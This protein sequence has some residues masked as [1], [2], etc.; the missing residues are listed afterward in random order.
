MMARLACPSARTCPGS[1]T[2]PRPEAE[3]LICARRDARPGSQRA[4]I[5][6]DLAHPRLRSRAQPHTSHGIA[7]HGWKCWPLHKNAMPE[8][9][10]IGRIGLSCAA[11][12][13]HKT[14][15]LAAGMLRHRG[16]ANCAVSSR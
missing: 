9:A 6:G 1:P 13:M 7:D 4:E 16:H 10:H 2:G 8:L 11:L 12:M 14:Y 5:F 15:G 3:L